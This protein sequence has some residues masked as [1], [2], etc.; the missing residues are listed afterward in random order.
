MK[1]YI[2]CPWND[3]EY[4]VKIK[5]LFKDYGVELT[6]NEYGK[7]FDKTLLENADAVIFVLNKRAFEQ[8]DSTMSRGLK[9]EVSV[10]KDKNCYIA[11]TNK[12]GLGIYDATNYGYKIEGK[13]GTKD[14]IFNRLSVYLEDNKLLEL[15]DVVNSKINRLFL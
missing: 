14:S 1:I 11:Y 5:E 12:D 10:A 6:S 4:L 13:I 3:A 7:T 2:S 8:S 9:K 15:V